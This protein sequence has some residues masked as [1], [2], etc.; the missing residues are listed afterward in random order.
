VRINASLLIATRAC[1]ICAKWQIHSI[2]TP[3]HA[4]ASIGGMRFLE[5]SDA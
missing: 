4:A 5:P 1:R 2:T 3:P